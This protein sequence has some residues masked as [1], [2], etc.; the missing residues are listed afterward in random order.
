MH[1]EEFYNYNNNDD[2]YYNYNNDYF[3]NDSN[4]IDIILY[5]IMSY[6]NIN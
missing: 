6:L 3:Y 2:Y 4:N 5:N 1:F